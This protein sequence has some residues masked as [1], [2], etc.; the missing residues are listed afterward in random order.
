MGPVFLFDMGVVVFVIGPA[1]GKVDRLFAI[2]KMTQEVII[3]KLAA[4]IGIKP[5]DRKRKHCF[6]VFDLIQ[7]A[8]FTF[9][10][11]SP[12]FGPAR[13]DINEVNGVGE[14]SQKRFATMGHRVGFQEPWA[15]YVPLVGVYGDF[16]SEQRSRFG[17]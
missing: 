14:H 12:L 7:D 1:A 10:S 6:D 13:S 3:E 9:S 8:F 15:G 16:F 17:R 11:Y 2:G 5:Q 4:I